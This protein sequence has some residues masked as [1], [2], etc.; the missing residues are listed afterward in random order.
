MDDF[1]S[2]FERR[3]KLVFEEFSYDGSSQTKEAMGYMLFAGG[4]RFRPNLMY[5][6][7]LAANLQN[8]T[9][10]SDA[11][12]A[13]HSAVC[14]D[15]GLSRCVPN[16]SLDELVLDFAV[17]MECIHSYSLIHDDL[18][19]MDDDDMR[20]GRPTVH[21]V[22]GEAIALL[23]GDGLLNLAAEIMSNRCRKL[24]DEGEHLFL[25]RAV[26]SMEYLLRAS[27]SRGMVMGQE[28]DMSD[29]PL[30]LALVEQIDLLKTGALIRASIV[31][32]ALLGGVIPSAIPAFEELGN[33]TGLVFQITDDLLDQFGDEAEVGKTLRTD[34][35][36]DKKTLIRILGVEKTNAY[37]AKCVGRALELCE[38]LGLYTLKNSIRILV[39]RKK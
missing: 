13:F 38:K 11:D 10:L 35:K 18:P 36:Q 16:S 29:V 27:G 12:D 37:L 20:R 24:A 21:K 15:L 25:L 3:M 14:E 39:G 17:A 6:S 7:Y 30:T 22:Y 4:K 28:L 34:E 1:L 32:G 8:G 9:P 2:L 31:A 23:A 26:R 19:C 33:L 5:E